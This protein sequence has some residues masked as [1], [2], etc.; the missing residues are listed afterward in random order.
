MRHT[1]GNSR[2]NCLAPINIGHLDFHD[3]KFI[4]YEIKTCLEFG[5]SHNLSP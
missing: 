3:F 2:F 5:L 1:L 4:F